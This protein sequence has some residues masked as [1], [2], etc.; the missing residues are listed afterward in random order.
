[1]SFFFCRTTTD[2]YAQ[3]IDYRETIGMTPLEDIRDGI[4]TTDGNNISD[5]ESW[6]T[7]AIDIVI[8][9]LYDDSTDEVKFMRPG[10]S[11]VESYA[12]VGT[13]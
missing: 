1:M 4:D 7:P 13:T 9:R 6:N 5:D 2:A 8:S 12:F 10:M 3:P 11:M